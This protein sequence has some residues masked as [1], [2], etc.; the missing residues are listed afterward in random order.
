MNNRSNNETPK[1]MRVK[2]LA[3]YLGIGKSTIWLYARKGIIKGNKVSSYITLF[4]VGEVEKAL[5]KNK[6]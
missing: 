6:N 3:K 1:Y 5:F 2:E 4:D